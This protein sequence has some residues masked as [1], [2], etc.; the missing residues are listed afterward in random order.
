MLCCENVLSE[1]LRDKI[2]KLLRNMNEVTHLEI[3]NIESSYLRII[4]TTHANVNSHS[5]VPL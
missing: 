5:L 4:L 1:R 3:R 2:L